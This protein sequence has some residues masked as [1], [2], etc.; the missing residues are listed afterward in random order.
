MHLGN[1][2]GSPM[3]AK[4]LTIRHLSLTEVNNGLKRIHIKFLQPKK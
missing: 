4:H 1:S 2:T 3:K